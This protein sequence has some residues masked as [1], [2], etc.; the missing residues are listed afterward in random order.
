MA[1]RIDA[2][3]QEVQFTRQS[4]AA[5]V[6]SKNRRHILFNRQLPMPSPRFVQA[7]DAA[8]LFS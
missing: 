1:A 6:C 5:C 3:R 8:D 4:R 2:W 7:G